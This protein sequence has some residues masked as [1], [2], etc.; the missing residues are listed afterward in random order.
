MARSRSIAPFTLAVLVAVALGVVAWLALAGDPSSSETTAEATPRAAAPRSTSTAAVAVDAPLAPLRD[1]SA[2]D[3]AQIA[4]ETRAVVDVAAERELSEALW[5]EGRVQFPEGA[6]LDEE[7]EIVAD[8]KSFEHVG[9]PK[10]EHRVRVERDGR[11]RVAFSKATKSGSLRLEGRYC[12][13]DAPLKLKPS[14]PP[15]DIVLEPLLGGCV[16]GVITPPP[17][18]SDIESVRAKSRVTSFAWAVNET[19]QQR[20]APIGADWRYEL[21][22]LAPH[23]TRQVKY[24]PMQWAVFTKDDVKV[25]AGRTLRLDIVCRLGARVTGRIVDSKG[26]GVG[27][28]GL[29]ARVAPAAGQPEAFSVRGVQ[30]DAAGHFSLTGVQPGLVKLEVD[31]DGY[32]SKE[33]EVGE[34]VDGQV[35]EGFEITLDSGNFV[36]GVVKWNDGTPAER[37]WVQVEEKRDDARSFF[38]EPKRHRVD[39]Q[40]RFEITGL[41]EGPYKVVATAAEGSKPQLDEQGAPLKTSRNSGPKWRAERTAVVAGADLELVLQPGLSV[42]GVVRDDTGAPVTKFML[43]ASPNDGVNRFGR[44]SADVTSRFEAADGRFVLEGLGE[45][46]WTVTAEAKGYSASEPLAVQS[47]HAGPELSIV[48]A[49]RARVTGVVVDVTGKPVPNA[50]VEIQQDLPTGGVRMEHDWG[51]EAD[52]DGRF[53]FANAPSGLLRIH[54]K[55]PKYAN[56]PALDV[57]VAPAATISD[58]RLVLSE[59]GRI[60]GRIHESL[61][62][63]GRTWSISLSGARGVWQNAQAGSDGVFVLERVTPGEH[64]LNAHAREAQSKPGSVARSFSTRTLT[65]TAKVE[66][67]ATVELVLGA[68]TGVALEVRGRVSLGGR[69]VE[70]ARVVVSRKGFSQTGATAADGSYSLYVDGAGAYSVSAS[71]ANGGASQFAQ[72]DVVEGGPTVCDFEFA[73]G[74]IRGRVIDAANEPVADAAVR[75]SLVRAAN[76]D[77]RGSQSAAVQSG[78]SGVFEFEGLTPGEYRLSVSDPTHFGDNAARFGAFSLENVVVELD[79]EREDLVLRVEPPASLRCRVRGLDGSPA[80]GAR[81]E[82]R[83]PAG[84]SPARGVRAATTDGAGQCNVTGLSTGEYVVLA[85]LEDGIGLSAL[86]RVASAQQSEAQ[87]ELRRGGQL[88]ITRVLAEGVSSKGKLSVLDASGFDWS[89]GAS[90]WTAEGEAW[91]VGPL[92]PGQYRVSASGQGVSSAVVTASVAS[93]VIA[94]VTLQLT[95]P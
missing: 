62:D 49:R 19:A 57:R 38:D 45:G 43:K 23:R 39:G 56:S 73:T 83:L 11:F 86:V 78:P 63:P 91:T 22:G 53:D 28:A 21:R 55:H 42:A 77:R 92:P 82:V 36:R 7:L 61:L 37:A 29:Q 31:R 70:Q 9:K 18:A 72:V 41:G 25:E 16:A 95:A 94:P 4:A 79:R 74:R 69:P 50:S 2:P 12:Y 51:G 67:G 71:L 89:L 75:A 30:T 90:P 10:G 76:E 46:A 60:R 59:G 33:V 58:L 80:I 6:P 64:P 5:V 68:P 3:R 15:A 66:A 27:N 8:G 81:V 40:G 14:S 17:N 52:K 24:E 34:L 65:A 85:R 1:D 26:E 93:G 48:L 20:S 47:P 35:R 13:L 54:A 44:S 32:L 88:S 84:A 87:V